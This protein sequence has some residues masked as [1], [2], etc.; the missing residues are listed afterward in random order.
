MH[1]T[2]RPLL[3]LLTVLGLLA[4]P[5]ALAATGPD[6]SRYQHPDG[7]PIDWQRVEASG[8]S[9]TWIKA[10]EGTAVRNAWFER[11]RSAAAAAGL[12]QGA[13]HYA[14]PSTSAGSAAAQ[15][16]FFASV[17]GDQQRRGTL[18]PA[19]DLE[20]SGGLS[21]AAL[22]AWTQTFLTTLEGLTG[23]TPVLYTG[24]SFWETSTGSSTAFTRYPLWIAHYTS[25]A[26]PRVPAWPAWTFW[27]Y[28]DSGRVPGIA[29]GVDMNRFSG[30]AADLARLALD[31]PPPPVEASQDAPLGV[32]PDAFPAPA[33]TAPSRYTALT[34]TRVADTRTGTGVPAG[35]VLGGL[36]VTLPDSVPADAAGVVLNVSAVDAAGTGYLRT[37]PAGQTPLT[38]ALS[39]GRGAA[40]TGLVVARTDAS[41]RAVLTTYAAAAHVVVD[42]LGYYDVRPG[43]GGHWVPVAPTRFVDS[44]TGIGTARGAKAGEV[45]VRLPDAVPADARG[46]VLNV[47]LV[48][49]VHDTFVR[50]AP[51][52]TAAQT[53]ALNVAGHT[54][55]TGLVMTSAA[56]REVTLTVFGGPAQ[57]VVDLVGYYDEGSETG[58]AF[59]G[60]APQ[61][62]LD[63]RNG[64]GALPGSRDITLAVPVPATATAATLALSVVDPI[65]TGYVRIAPA[66]TDPVTTAVSYSKGR[67]Q[68]ALAMTGLGPDRLVTVRLYGGAT[69]VVADLVGYAGRGLTPALGPLATDQRGDAGERQHRQQ[70]QAPRD[71]GELAEPADH[72][73]ADAAAD[74]EDQRGDADAR[75]RGPRRRRRRPPR[76]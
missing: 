64:V 37:A 68:T 15:A 3:V 35:R 50:V 1:L 51:R 70:H 44:R 69:A 47:S 62:F 40:S 59:V 30:S 75:R 7:Q 28:T 16:R 65:G 17:I 27:Q 19:L 66:G 46:A 41:R 63:T 72:G 36:T 57:V 55:R 52:G 42:L 8:P 6:V 60:T 25:A 14:R 11:D 33:D 26:Q 23:R 71:A 13:Y 9:F 39:Y 49:A 58:S 34:P 43:T 21:R 67:S 29:G 61:R 45:T 56:D 53:T 22:V 2:H 38:T 76:P 10:T 48:D 32:T 54:S 31:G 4:A 12:Y 73:G 5:A 18:P 20:S 74:E 24:P